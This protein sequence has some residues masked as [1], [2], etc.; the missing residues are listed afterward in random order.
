MRIINSYSLPYF[1]KDM[2]DIFLPNG[3]RIKVLLP[4]FRDITSEAGKFHQF[5][6]YQIRANEKWSPKK[7]RER[8]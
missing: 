7:H 6:A 4:E 8:R 3:R 5:Y 1:S 2:A